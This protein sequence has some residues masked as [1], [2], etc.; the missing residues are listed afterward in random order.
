MYLVWLMTLLLALSWFPLTAMYAPPNIHYQNPLWFSWAA[1]AGAIACG[2]FCGKIIRLEIARRNLIISAIPLLVALV[3]IPFPYSISAGFLLAAV[4]VAFFFKPPADKEPGIFMRLTTALVLCGLILAMQ[5]AILPLFYLLFSHFHRVEILA[6]TA[7]F[8]LQI[9]GINASHANGELFLQNVDQ[10]F[11]LI[12]SWDAL[13]LYAALNILAGGIVLFYLFST[14]KPYYVLL[15]ALLLAYMLVRYLFLIFIFIEVE[16]VNVFWRLDVTTLSWLPLP[17]VLYCLLPQ[18]FAGAASAFT[19]TFLISRHAIAPHKGARL[20]KAPIMEWRFAFTVALFA[21]SLIGFFGLADP[22]EKKSGRILIDE[23][24]SDWE[25]TTEEFN[26]SWYGEKSTYNYYSLA[27]YLKHFYTVDQRRETLTAELLNQYDILFIKTPTEPFAAK[28]IEA[29][30]RFVKQG[31]SLFLVGDH[32]NVF[33][34]TTNLNPLAEKFGAKFRYD[35]QY[36]LDGKLSIYYKPAVLPHPV[37]QNMPAFLFAAGCMLDAPLLAESAIIG[38]GVKSIYLDYSQKNFFPKNAKEKETIEFG[39]FVQAAGISFG[40]GRVFLFTDSTV[41]SNFYMFIPGKP[42]LLLGI[43]EWLNRRNGWMFHWRGLLLAVALTAA[44]MT[45]VWGRRIPSGKLIPVLFFTGFLIT[46]LTICSLQVWN[47]H[48]YPLPKPHTELITVNF[49]SEH[50][51]FELPIFHVTQFP[52]SSFHTFYVWLQRLGLVPALKPSFESALAEGGVAILINPHHPFSLEELLAAEAFLQKG[53][54]LLVLDDPRHGGHVIANQFLAYFGMHMAA[55][56]EGFS[57]V[58][59][60]KSKDD[61]AK[62]ASSFAGKIIGAP[63]LL[64]AETRLQP[65][66]PNPMTRS[67]FGH[68]NN[69]L[70]LQPVLSADFMGMSRPSP[71]FSLQQQWPRTSNQSLPDTARLWPVF[72]AKRIGKGALAAMAS[73]YVFTD[74]EMGFTT[75]QPNEN[76]R[77]IYELEYWIFREV[78]KIK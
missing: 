73:S 17:L 36:D 9:F 22:G 60:G 18:S 56:P 37:V 20:R 33:G 11:A 74:H 58:N 77:R 16:Q 47:G 48:Y 34:I 55:A 68:M 19:F 64:F 5:T 76:Q 3:L 21:L 70:D 53:G 78:L 6:P 50:S 57:T 51:R 24:H 42:E 72:A 28:E 62:I 27:E 23:K 35:G 52:E 61:T 14:R 30:V 8:L 63:T 66:D 15:P 13:G 44:A 32:T 71:S 75:T 49:E 38:H 4:V 39:L 46:P 2:F 41:W 26:T 7:S 65:S 67:P 10:V 12:P 31:G 43:M 40:T 29:I 59:M 25:W 1:L 54:K 69:A 45:M